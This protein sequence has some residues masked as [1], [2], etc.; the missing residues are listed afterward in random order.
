M[1]DI[2]QRMVKGERVKGES[3]DEKD[4]LQLIHDLDHIGGHIKGSIT[5]KKYMQNEIWSLIAFQGAPS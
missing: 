4:C 1:T 2:S 3:Q 5:S